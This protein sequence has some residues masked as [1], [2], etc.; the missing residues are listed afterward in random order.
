MMMI[1]AFDDIC[2][3]FALL[4]ADSLNK[5]IIYYINVCAVANELQWYIRALQFWNDFARSVNKQYLNKSSVTKHKE[6]F[7][8]KTYITQVGSL[9]QHSSLIFFTSTIPYYIHFILEMRWYICLF[10]E[11]FYPRDA[12]LARVIEIATCPSVCPSVC[13]CVRPSRAG[14]VSK[15]RMLAAWFLHHLVAP[16]L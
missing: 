12:M 13:P 3:R 7:L 2:E 6:S 9:L 4:L 11:G 5:H 10:S 15:R 8:K 14:I 16:R 1:W